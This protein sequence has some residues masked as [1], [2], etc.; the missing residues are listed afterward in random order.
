[1]RLDY[2][3]KKIEDEAENF[4]VTLDEQTH[5]DIIELTNSTE[6]SSFIDSLQNDSF[7]SQRLCQDPLE[8]FFG[9]QRH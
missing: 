4:G 8:N 2:L 3:K 7:L 9:C 1:M 5:N 6:A